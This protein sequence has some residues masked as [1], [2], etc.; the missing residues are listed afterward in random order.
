MWYT[1]KKIGNKITGFVLDWSTGNQLAGATEKQIQ[2]LKEIHDEV[3]NNF[4]IYL[5]MKDFNPAKP[6][7]LI[8]KEI[9][10]F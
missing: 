8:I 10:D 6:L 2:L 9:H 1:E 7:I 4:S 5:Q 3:N